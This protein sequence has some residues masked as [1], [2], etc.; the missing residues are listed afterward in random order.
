MER[1]IVVFMDEDAAL[2]AVQKGDVDIAYTFATHADRT[3]DGYELTAF[4]TVD[5]RG[6][7][8]PCIRREV[9]AC[10]RRMSRTTRAMM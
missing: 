10:L 9:R 5:S 1:V 3:F 6:I 7:S 2:A 8:L 4:K